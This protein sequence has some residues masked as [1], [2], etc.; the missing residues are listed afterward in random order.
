MSQRLVYLST[1]KVGVNIGTHYETMRLWM[2]KDD[3]V[4]TL[5]YV[6]QP[7]LF[8]EYLPIANNMLK[9]FKITR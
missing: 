6:T 9:S 2:I 4:Y 3:N 5:V 8:P 1:K 7:N